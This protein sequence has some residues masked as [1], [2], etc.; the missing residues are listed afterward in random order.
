M[1]DTGAP[2]NLPYPLPTDLVRDGADAIKDLAE[3]VALG[4]NE[5][6][7]AGIGSNVVQAVEDD[8]FTV[9]GGTL[10]D[11][12]GL[13]ATITPSSATS[14]ILVIADVATSSAAGADSSSILVT[15]GSDNGLLPPTAGAGLFRNARVDAGTTSGTLRTCVVA[16]VSPE[17]TSPVTYKVKFSAVGSAGTAHVNRNGIENIRTSSTLT[18]IE[19]AA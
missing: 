10:Q 1:A 19:V 5:A 2:W 8:R 11:V 17:T 15:D 9:S 13:S 12:P 16:L 4:L 6:Q 14:K 7:N 3:Q 18:L